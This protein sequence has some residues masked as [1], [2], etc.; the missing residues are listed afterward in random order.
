MYLIEIPYISKFIF[1]QKDKNLNTLKEIPISNISKKDLKNVN[2]YK[3]KTPNN[4]EIPLPII[5]NKIIKTNN[6]LMCS[7][8]LIKQIPRLKYIY[9]SNSFNGKEKCVF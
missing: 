6:K 1:V 7:N 9:V 5:N 2:F 3:I 4:L 8:E